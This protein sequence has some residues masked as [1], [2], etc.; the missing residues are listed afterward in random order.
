MMTAAAG[1]L[2]VRQSALLRTKRECHC[3]ERLREEAI[4]IGRA[5]A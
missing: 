1:L 4:S 5:L 2:L 3:E